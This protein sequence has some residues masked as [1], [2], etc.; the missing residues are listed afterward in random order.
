MATGTSSLV[1]EMELSSSVM[2]TGFN[3]MSVGST[4][5]ETSTS[6]LMGRGRNVHYDKA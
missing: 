4:A 6:N 1:L 2:P 3:S 5:V